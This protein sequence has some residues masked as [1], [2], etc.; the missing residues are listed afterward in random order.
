MMVTQGWDIGIDSSVR[1]A[2]VLTELRRKIPT[3][4]IRG[5]KDEVIASLVTCGSSYCASTA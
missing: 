4:T 2:R 3:P 1:L 5:N